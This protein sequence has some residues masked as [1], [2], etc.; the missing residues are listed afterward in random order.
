[1]PRKLLLRRIIVAMIFNLIIIIAFASAEKNQK[2]KDLIILSI[3]KVSSYLINKYTPD[4]SPECKEI[5]KVAVRCILDPRSDKSTGHLNDLVSVTEKAINKPDSERVILI[6][7]RASSNA[8][9][10]ES[11]ISKDEIG[12]N[13]DNMSKKFDKS[14]TFA[15]VNLRSGNIDSA[16]L[17]LAEAEKY[18]TCS[19]DTRYVEMI[20]ILIN[21]KTIWKP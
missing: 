11:G 10:N 16:K 12:I 13:I 17:Y 14:A 5:Q 18:D 8:V 2:N 20:K 7:N 21:N 1:M 4:A 6:V 9:F 3:D 15:I 19:R